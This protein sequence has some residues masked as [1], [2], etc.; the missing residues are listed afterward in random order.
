MLTGSGSSGE[1]GDATI[2]STCGRTMPTVSIRFTSGSVVCV[3]NETGLVSVM[4]D[5]AMSLV[6]R[7]AETDRML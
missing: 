4:P 2:A 3:W 7:G 6:V 1:S 5:R